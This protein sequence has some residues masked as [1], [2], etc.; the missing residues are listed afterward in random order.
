[1]LSKPS[2]AFLYLDDIHIIPHFI[3]PL[4]RLYESGEVEV[5]LYTYRGKHDYL[6]ALFNRLK[7]SPQIIRYLDTFAYRKLLNRIKKR[8]YPSHYYLIRKHWKELLDHDVLV[9]NDLIED[10]LYEKRKQKRPRFVMLMHGAGDR[11]YMIGEAYSHRMRHFDLISAQGEKIKEF[12]YRMGIDAGRIALCGYTKF[13][14]LQYLPRKTFFEKSRPTVL[15]N[16]HFS[17]DLSSW[18][19]WGRE[20]LDFFYRNKRFNLIFAPHINLFNKRGF[21]NPSVI[22]G[23]Y[24][25][26]ENILIDLGSPA[27]VQ[28]DYTRIADIYLGDVSSQVYEFYFNPRPA[29]F[30]NPHRVDWRNDIH[31][32]VWHSGP[33]IDEIESLEHLLNTAGRWHKDYLLVQR[34]LFAFTFSEPREGTASECISNKILDLIDG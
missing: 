18:Y 10:Y 31:Y 4:K 20:I 33:V 27:A 28:M 8:K 14:L 22:S 30:L 34:E 9:F 1:M 24:W 2:V 23:H 15:Y 25:D 5:I 11:A 29:I 16:P 6:L 17:R 26:A 13:E 12:Y 32:R 7:I 3:M 19:D 21:L